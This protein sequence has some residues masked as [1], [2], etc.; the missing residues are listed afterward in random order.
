MRYGLLIVVD[1]ISTIT[2]LAQ[3][4]KLCKIPDGEQ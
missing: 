1:V 2:F 4:I 3:K